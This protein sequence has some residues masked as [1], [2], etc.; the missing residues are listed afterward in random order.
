M[1]PIESVKIVAPMLSDEAK[2]KLLSDMREEILI[3]KRQVKLSRRKIR[4]LLAL[5]ATYEAT[6]I[7]K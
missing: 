7:S 5:I 1:T 3:E 2:Q 6:V 4:V